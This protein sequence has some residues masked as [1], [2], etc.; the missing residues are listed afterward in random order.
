LVSEGS[1]PYFAQAAGRL[2]QRLGIET[3]RTPGTHFAYLDHPDELAQTVRPF[4]NEVSN[5]QSSR[6]SPGLVEVMRRNVL[7][8]MGAGPKWREGDPDQRKHVILHVRFGV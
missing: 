7:H 4:L 8:L 6:S 2:A 3:T 5:C 1:I